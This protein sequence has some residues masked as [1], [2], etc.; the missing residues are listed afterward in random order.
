MNIY[1]INLERA[2]DR[3]QSMLEQFN[4]SEFAPT[5]IKA[6]DGHDKNFPYKKYKSLIVEKDRILHYPRLCCH[7]SHL[8]AWKKVAQQTEGG[9]ILE[10]DATIDLKRLRK[11]IKEDL[12]SLPSDL[13]LLYINA[14]SQKWINRYASAKCA[15]IDRQRF[16]FKNFPILRKIR[17]KY[18]NFFYYRVLPKFFRQD[19]WEGKYIK[20]SDVMLHRIQCGHYK[21]GIQNKGADGYYLTPEGAKKLVMIAKA[22]RCNYTTDWAMEYHSITREHQKFIREAIPLSK[23]PAYFE[24][25]Y[26]TEDQLKQTKQH[27]KISL[28]SY[29]LNRDYITDLSDHRENSTIERDLSQP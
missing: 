8:K 14:R 22:F 15:A 29:L 24:A 23:R 6:I 17:K 28:N 12:K 18:N 7:L 3:H 25:H 4:D 5:F 26:A 10:D 20:V 1:V 9:I 16:S 13:D 2:K 19:Q 21:N 11:F 27:P